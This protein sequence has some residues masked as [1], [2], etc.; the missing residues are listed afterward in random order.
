MSALDDDLGKF[1]GQGS[2]T[3]SQVAVRGRS[4]ASLA[5]RVPEPG[6]QLCNYAA[7]SP[8]PEQNHAFTTLTSTSEEC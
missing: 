6:T 2:A 3:S 8:H 4:A 1:L 7:E 5:E